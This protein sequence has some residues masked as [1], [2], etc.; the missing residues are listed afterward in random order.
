MFQLRRG[1]AVPTSSQ[2][3]E[4]KALG[5]SLP[6]L[7]KRS[8]PHADWRRKA[9]AVYFDLRALEERSGGDDAPVRE[10]ISNSGS[11][12]AL[13]QYLWD[14]PVS[15]EPLHG[16]SGNLCF[17][18]DEPKIADYF[19]RRPANAGFRKRSRYCASKSA[20]HGKLRC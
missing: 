15:L 14:A 2:S 12:F 16:S 19:R 4:G 17:A 13:L 20:G 3:T 10:H 7:R 8:C 11:R 1:C 9:S 18:A 5:N 6:E